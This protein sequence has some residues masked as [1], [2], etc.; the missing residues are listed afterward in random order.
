MLIGQTLNTL[1]NIQNRQRGGP[2]S[3]LLFTILLEFLTTAIKQVK[4]IKD[5]SWKI[6]KYCNYF[7]ITW[8]DEQIMC[9]TCLLKTTKPC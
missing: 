1:S 3:L 9:K 8:N 2:P 5:K 4:E 6:S 7:H